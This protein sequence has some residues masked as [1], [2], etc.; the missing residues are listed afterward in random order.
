MVQDL[1]R[2]NSATTFQPWKRCYL[3]QE[4]LL[5]RCFNSA[6]TFQPWKRGTNTANTLFTYRFNSA[7]TFQPWKPGLSCNSIVHHHGASIRPRPFSR[8]NNHT[9]P[10]W[11]SHFCRLQFGHDLSAVETKILLPVWGPSTT[12]LQFGH[13]LSAVET[14][15]GE[16]KDT[17]E[18]LRFNSATT[19]QPWKQDMMKIHHKVY[20]DASI[21]PRPFSRGNL[22]NL[23]HRRALI[24][25]LQFG[26]DL[27][28]VETSH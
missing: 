12:S 1:R 22:S 7:T 27:S 24:T 14:L 28:A 5:F 11:G 16:R 2:F 15:F 17:C 26:H 18:S 20:S 13:D 8:G 10:Y 3:N 6:T 19:F 4:I 25:G 21:R 9:Q 23:K